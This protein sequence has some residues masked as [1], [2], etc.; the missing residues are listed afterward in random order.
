VAN[1]EHHFAVGDIAQ[2]GG[3]KRC[4]G[5]IHMGHYAATNV[6]QLMLAEST[7]LKPEFLALQNYP[8][9]MGLALGHTAVSYSPDSG[10]QHGEKQLASLF[11]E[12]VGYTS[13]SLSCP[14]IA[15]FL[16]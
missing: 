14:S 1:A 16:L 9:V 6:H 5:A 11:G 13:M 7:Q 3:I 15:M 4:G 2:W 10:V 12:D 8:P